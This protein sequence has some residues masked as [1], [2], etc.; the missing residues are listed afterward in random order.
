MDQRETESNADQCEYSADLRERTMGLCESIK[1][2]RVRVQQIRLYNKICI[3]PFLLGGMWCGSPGFELVLSA[4]VKLKQR[5][6]GA[7]VSTVL[8]QDLR[9]W[10]ECG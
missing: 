7:F 9:P 4:I 2:I 3:L 6:T 10:Q 1:M 5:V 8:A